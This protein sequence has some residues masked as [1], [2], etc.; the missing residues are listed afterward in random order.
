MRKQVTYV[1][2]PIYAVST[3]ATA[4]HRANLAY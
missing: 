3:V 2:L 4:S 1:T